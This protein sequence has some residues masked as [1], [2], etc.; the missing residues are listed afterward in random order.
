MDYEII[1][2]EPNKDIK[3]VLSTIG[4]NSALPTFSSAFT[5]RRQSLEDRDERDAVVVYLP[6]CSIDSSAIREST[7]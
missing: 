3:K 6:T 5:G 7:G 2:E 4:Q 1:K